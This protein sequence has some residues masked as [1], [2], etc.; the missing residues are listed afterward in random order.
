M[1]TVSGSYQIHLTSQKK[2]SIQEMYI[3]INKVTNLPTQVKICQNNK[4]STITI[5]NF[6]AK[7]LSDGLFNFN[8]KNYPNAEIIDLR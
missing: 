6:Q 4:W 5:T 8:S 3:T 7:D 1:K 2:Q